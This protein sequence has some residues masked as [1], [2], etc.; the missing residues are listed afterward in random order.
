MIGS[1]GAQQI[2]LPD[3]KTHMERTEKIFKLAYSEFKNQNW[4]KAITYFQELRSIDTTYIHF[5]F[6]SFLA[7]C[8]KQTGEVDSGKIVYEKPI[9]YY[10][11]RQR[12]FH[13]EGEIVASLKKWSDMYPEFPP[14][15]LEKNGFIPNE[16]GPQP[17]NGFQQIIQN[18]K[19]SKSCK[20]GKVIIRVLIDK[21]G[22]QLEH[23]ILK[24]AG[25]SCDEAVINAVKKTKFKP[26]RSKSRLIETWVA[27]PIILN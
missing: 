9:S 26:A 25:R 22:N 12:I 24:S 17:I 18:L 10:A 15:L 16:E 3:F 5:E 8:Y 1:V 13:F 4:Q 21:N 2:K 19:R 14:E 27:I 6:I 11:N 20:S 23:K 7:E